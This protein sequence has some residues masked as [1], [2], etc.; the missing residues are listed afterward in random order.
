MCH[1]V[2]RGPY[3]P[4]TVTLDDVLFGNYV[5]QVQK[6]Q[7]LCNPADK[8]GEDPAAP[9]A[10]EHLAGY[11]IK[12]DP[13]FPRFEKR[14]GVSV[15][16][17]FH[18]GGILMDVVKPDMLMVPSTKDLSAPPAPLPP[19]LINH[20]KCYK[21]TQTRFRLD[22]VTIEDQFFGAPFALYADTLIVNIKKPFRLCVAT[23]KN[24]EGVL[25][26]ATHL[27][28]YKTKNL[29]K[30]VDFEPVYIDNQIVS[31]PI[32]ITKTR[33]LCVPSAVNALCGD[34]ITEPPFEECDGAD[35]GACSGLCSGT[36][37]CP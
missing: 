33:E 12:R 2:R 30:T 14:L 36:C 8:N 27:L 5:A 15:A 10:I 19:D 3:E 20:F 24:G 18:P 31:K 17:Q 34:G 13:T 11:R 37:Q 1:E 21:V 4:L 16:N 25:L 35:D 26:P 23:D 29:P 9:S 6:Q 22:G 7:R 32:R 28:C